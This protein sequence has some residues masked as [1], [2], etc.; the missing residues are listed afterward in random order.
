M[1]NHLF[2]LLL[3][4]LI[5]GLLLVACDDEGATAETITEEGDVTADLEDAAEGDN[6]VGCEGGVCPAP[7]PSEDTEEVPAEEASTE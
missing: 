2:Y 3:V 1:K 7:I 4:V 6:C 5:G